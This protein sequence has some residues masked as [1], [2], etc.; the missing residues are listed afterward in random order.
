MLSLGWTAHRVLTWCRGLKDPS[1]FSRRLPREQL[2]RLDTP[3]WT[4]APRERDVLAAAALLDSLAEPPRILLTSATETGRRRAAGLR[5]VAVVGRAPHD[6]A[7]P[8]GRWLDELKPYAAFFVGAELPVETLRLAAS[9]GI[10][11]CVIDGHLSE[12]DFRRRRRFAGVWRDALRDVW[13]AT[14]RTDDDLER[15]VR[16]G[17]PQEAVVAVGDIAHDAVPPSPE[18]LGAAMR[19]I[20]EAG[21]T[22]PIVWVAGG[23]RPMEEE[24]VLA[25]YQS[26][27]ERVPA[28]RLVVAPHDPARKEALARRL[29][30]AGI[31]DACLLVEDPRAL[32]PYYACGDLAFAGGTLAPS[33]DQNLL[34]PALAAVPVLFGPHAGAD[35]PASGLVEHGGG[36]LVGRRPGGADD[37]Y[38]LSD[39]VVRLA[40]DPALREEAGRL[41]Q[42]LARSLAGA[43]RRTAQHLGP[44][45]RAP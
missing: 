9:R 41:A 15:F 30:N 8:A 36:F 12:E 13:K 20:E 39:A 35:T 27:R 14:V 45:L 4:H 21:W 1:G 3:L 25:A 16:L 11:A 37:A 17:L 7:S 29:R 18:Q 33:R 26:A 32:G 10:R 28:L 22:D 24:P 31:E 5:S 44:V 42:E 6:L 19:R 40:T 38:S 34:E 23:V 2:A 43:V